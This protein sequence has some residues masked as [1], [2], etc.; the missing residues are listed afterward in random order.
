MKGGDGSETR[1]YSRQLLLH[2]ALAQGILREAS[3]L[4]VGAGGLGCS[5]L[6][7]LVGAGVGRLTICDSDRVEVSNLHRQILFTERDAG[8]AKAESAVNLLR[9]MNS[10]VT[11]VAVARHCAHDRWTSELVNSHD[12]IVD[13]SDNV[14]TRYLL[15]DVCFLS[16]KVLIS[17]AALGNEG[18]LTR[19]GRSGGPC[20]RCVVPGPSFEARRRCVDQGVLGPVPGMLGA[21]Q[22]LDVLRLFSNSDGVANKMR[23]FDGFTLRS[24]GLP[25][26]RRTCALCGVVQSLKSHHD[27][28][29]WAQNQAL[30]VDANNS[31]CSFGNL[32]PAFPIPLP[33]ENEITVLDLKAAIDLAV[34]FILVDV[35]EETQFSMCR[36]LPAFSLPL[37]C[38]IETPDAA[39]KSL[40]NMNKDGSITFVL[41]RRGLDSTTATAALLRLGCSNACNI[42]G[43]LDA[44]RCSVDSQ[45]P[46]Y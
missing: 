29:Q 44:W 37:R 21:L 33:I 39:I 17:A 15:N 3:V 28:R 27:S 20:Y 45:F 16:G 42:A 13:C 9:A 18:M 5:C 23:I 24:F 4:V 26:R 11:L 10:G 46:V 12:V 31:M 19:W 25:P 2:G 40:N 32:L 36:L 6:F 41:C 34:P 35:R 43:G 30:N 38:I 22:A 14:G 7:Y 8:K 1:R